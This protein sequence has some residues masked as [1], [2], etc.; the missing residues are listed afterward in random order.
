M[1]SI[2]LTRQPNIELLHRTVALHKNQ[3]YPGA[4]TQL[5]CTLGALLGLTL[6]ACGDNATIVSVNISYADD[7]EAPAKVHVS[8]TQGSSNTDDTFDAPTNKGVVEMMTTDVPDRGYFKRYDLSG[9]ADGDATLKVDL[10]NA[11]G[12]VYMTEE[13]TFEVQENEVVAAYAEFELPPVD[14]TSGDTGSGATDSGATD[15]AA[16]DSGATSAPSSAASDASTSAADSSVSDAASDSGDGDASS[17][18]DAAS[19]DAAT[20]DAQ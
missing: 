9:W 14:E 1:P 16:T 13:T 17:T 12:T 18:G 15:T 19:S 3:I 5:R 4:M 11:A 20:A 6:A 2:G 7:V 8:L 10:I